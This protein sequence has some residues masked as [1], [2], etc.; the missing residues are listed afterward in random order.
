MSYHLPLSGVQGGGGI[1]GPGTFCKVTDPAEA[2]T[3]VD[4]FCKHGPSAIDTSQLYGFGTSE[5][6]RHIVHEH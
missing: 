1:G 6:V 3:L 4:A 5:A 2:Q